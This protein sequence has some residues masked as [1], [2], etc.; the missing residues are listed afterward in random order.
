MSIPKFIFT[1]VLTVTFLWSVEQASFDEALKLYRQFLQVQEQI[2]EK[3]TYYDPAANKPAIQLLEQAEQHARK[4]DISGKFVNNVDLLA[5]I[6]RDQ[7]TILFLVR[8]YKQAIEKCTDYAKLAPQFET[9]INV[10]NALYLAYNEIGNKATAAKHLLRAAALKYM[11]GSPEYDFV[12]K[13]TQTGEFDKN[14]FYDLRE[15]GD[16]YANFVFKVS[17]DS[18]K[19]AKAFFKE[20]TEAGR[21]DCR[22][23]VLDFI[24]CGLTDLSQTR[25][26]RILARDVT[27]DLLAEYARFYEVEINTPYKLADQRPIME[28]REHKWHRLATLGAPNVELRIREKLARLKK[29]L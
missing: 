11:K 21:A 13:K 26:P 29:G 15:M 25:N 4:L 18:L 28:E 12:L 8:E 5:A 24:D 2:T 22:Y 23:D 3:K 7:C 20:C 14:T 9:E 27:A 1:A 16:G 17:V 10:H 19:K 6:L